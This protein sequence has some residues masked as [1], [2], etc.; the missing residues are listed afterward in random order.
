[1]WDTAE[2]TRTTI[3]HDM[4]CSECGH[5]THTYLPCSDECHCVPQRPFSGLRSWVA[6]VK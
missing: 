2:M 6:Q 3:A 5:A 1:M 4:P